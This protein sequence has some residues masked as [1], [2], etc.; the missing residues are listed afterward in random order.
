[1]ERLRLFGKANSHPFAFYT[2][3]FTS[4]EST[5]ATSGRDGCKLV[6]VF[7]VKKEIPP[8]AQRIGRPNEPEGKT[9][10]KMNIRAQACR[11]ALR[12]KESFHETD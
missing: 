12:Q 8:D 2:I 9:G 1:L 5:V 11:P 3:E 10:G 6:A 4:P 7:E